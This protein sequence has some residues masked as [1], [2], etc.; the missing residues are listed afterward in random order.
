MAVTEGNI[1]VGGT[2]KLLDT[3]EVVQDSGRVTH[4]EAVVLTDPEN[5][6]ARVSVELADNREKYHLNTQDPRLDSVIDLLSDLLE[7]QKLTN[8]LL[9][10]ILQ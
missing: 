4:R 5:N 7:Q 9:E 10:G 6:D 3:T 8:I 2:D 1:A